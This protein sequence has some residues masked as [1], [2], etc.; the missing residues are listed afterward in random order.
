M[1][2]RFKELDIISEIS[3]PEKESTP[4][5]NKLQL[6]MFNSKLINDTCFSNP[7]VT[8]ETPVV[9]QIS[10]KLLNIPVP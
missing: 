4:R 2:P 3:Q 9:S 1:S 6:N 8:F 5:V 7:K 10:S